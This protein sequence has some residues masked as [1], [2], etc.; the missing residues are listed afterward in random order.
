M[1]RICHKNLISGLHQAG[2]TCRRKHTRGWTEAKE[3][4]TSLTQTVSIY[5]EDNGSSFPDRSLGS[6]PEKRKLLD[7]HEEK[8]LHKINFSPLLSD[9]PMFD[10]EVFTVNEVFMVSKSVR[11]NT[12]LLKSDSSLS[13]IQE[14]LIYSTF[15]LLE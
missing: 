4:D 11:N 15:P 6:E 9:D 2:S 1:V 14:G 13:N 7:K 5:P 3:S 8:I 12:G 10:C